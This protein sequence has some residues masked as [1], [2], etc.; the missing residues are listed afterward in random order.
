MRFHAQTAGS[1]LTAKQPFNNVARVAIQALAAV[2]GGC[3]SLHTNSMDEA[4]AL[5]TEEAVRTALR[6]QQLLAFE[7]GA[8]DVIDPLGGAFTVE[9]MTRDLEEEAWTILETI[10]QMGGM[11]SAIESG[12]VQRQIEKAA[13]EH[14]MA[15][16]S[17]ER[18]VVGVTRF[19]EET[20][21]ETEMVLLQ[22]PPGLEE[23]K[24]DE[25]EKL[26]LG[27]DRDR[28]E[29]AFDKVTGAAEGTANIVEAIFG[30]VQE[31]ATLGEVADRLR[32]VFGEY[33]DGATFR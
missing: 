8:A 1:T 5:P 21:G 12:Y 31:E 3:Q 16:E 15:V 7:H 18:V 6:T 30:A 26:R 29:R 13:Y 9:S 2:L 4:L 20:A 25:L 33:R 22:I 19:E 24:A 23:K 27:R 11:V 10:E 14:Q 32:E 28:V 17:G